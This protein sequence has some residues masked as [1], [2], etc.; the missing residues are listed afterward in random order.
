MVRTRRRLT[1]AKS[2]VLIRA[3][4]K[5]ASN[6]YFRR[7]Q[8]DASNC[9]NIFLQRFKNAS[10]SSTPKQ[11]V[12]FKEIFRWATRS[13]QKNFNGNCAF[14]AFLLL[15][16]RKH[17]ISLQRA[18]DKDAIRSVLFAALKVRS[19][20]VVCFWLEEKQYNLLSQAH[21]AFESRSCK[22]CRNLA[23]SESYAFLRARSKITVR[24]AFPTNGLW[25]FKLLVA[26]RKHYMLME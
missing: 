13:Q 18:T 2:S 20:S 10:F 25:R 1:K 9:S 12:V 24:N 21:D 22:M 16:R 5:F 4:S 8:K 19:W 11:K 6:V 7:C 26:R 14:D 17:D 15:A 3:R 23:K